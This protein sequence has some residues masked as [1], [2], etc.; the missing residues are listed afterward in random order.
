MSDTET[1][2]PIFEQ[3]C[4]MSARTLSIMFIVT[5][6]ACAEDVPAPISDT[7]YK[8]VTDI[9]HTMELILNPAA[10]VIWSS[11]GTIITVEGRTE[12]APTTDEGWHAV[13]SAAA[14]VAETGNLLLMP[15]RNAGP[16]WEEYARDLT[17]AGAVAMQAA[18]DQN[19][20]ALFD[21]GGRIYQVCKAC[22]NQY[23]VNEGRAS[24]K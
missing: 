14:M 12:L 6:S 19:P 23:W 17:E 18:L 9:H 20:D 11:A 24:E 16:D 2:A 15:G 5:L 21:A 10:D 1:T 7:N 8:P 4:V 22:H 3:G 13:E